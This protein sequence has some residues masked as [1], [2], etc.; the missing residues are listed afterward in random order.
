MAHIY[1]FSYWVDL[2][3]LKNPYCRFNPKFMTW[4]IHEKSIFQGGWTVGF[5][6]LPLISYVFPNT[7]HYQLFQPI[8]SL[9]LLPLYFIVPESPRW[10]Y[11]VGRKKE[12]NEILKNI[13]VFNGQPET[14]KKFEDHQVHVHTINRSNDTTTSKLL[15]SQKNRIDQ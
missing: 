7:F 1:M 5:L 10:L 15:E 2:I 13:L 6:T 4:I 14:A 8:F 9:L 11:S 12:A 3:S